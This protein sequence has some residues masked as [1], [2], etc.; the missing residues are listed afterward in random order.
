MMASRQA[1]VSYQGISTQ[2]VSIQGITENITAINNVQVSDAG[3]SITPEEAQRHA[4]VAFIGNDLRTR[5]FEGREPIGKT[6]QIE[7]VPYEASGTQPRVKI[8]S[9]KI[10]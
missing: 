8:T 9:D 7:G 1:R 4:R 3:H 5:F 10:G 6:I 2:D